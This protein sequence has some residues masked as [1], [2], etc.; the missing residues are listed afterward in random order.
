MADAK[1]EKKDAAQAHKTPLGVRFAIFMLLVTAVVFLPSTIIFA[2]CMIPTMVAA[3]VDS[4]RQKT[5]WLTVG[6]MN[7]AGTVPVW[8]SLIDAGHTLSAAIQ[9]IFE[10]A[11]III[12]FG[13]AGVGVLIYNYVT[14]LIASVIQSK[15]E[16]RLR[17]IDKR[18]K[19]LVRKWGDA[20]ILK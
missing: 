19:G 11:S 9:L 14:P 4:N 20:V 18:Q 12:S 5:A 3:L 16:R 2:I 8:F 10:P 17:D 15:S 1:E 13:G 6:A 7:V